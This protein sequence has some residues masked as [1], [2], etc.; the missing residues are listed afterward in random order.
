MIEPHL[1][2]GIFFDLFEL[3]MM[4]ENHLYAPLLV[5]SDGSQDSGKPLNITHIQ[6][7]TLDKLMR[8]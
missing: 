8:C 6:P 1:S 7:I 5:I 4:L 3:P 2:G